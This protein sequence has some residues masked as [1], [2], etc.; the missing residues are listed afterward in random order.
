MGKMQRFQVFNPDD[1]F[2][3]CICTI[4]PGSIRFCTKAIPY[5]VLNTVVQTFAFWRLAGIISGECVDHI[6]SK[7]L[8]P[9]GVKTV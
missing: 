7:G 5:Y 9:E 6:R 1:D 3:K 4:P 2:Q 8:A